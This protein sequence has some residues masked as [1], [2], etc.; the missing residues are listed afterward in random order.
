VIAFALATG[1]KLW[2]YHDQEATA[3]LDDPLVA[4]NMFLLSRIISPVPGAGQQS[5]LVALHLKDGKP[6][7]QFDTDFYEA[8]PVMGP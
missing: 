1:A 7:W 3:S 4:G 2:Q 6:V 5:S 8:F